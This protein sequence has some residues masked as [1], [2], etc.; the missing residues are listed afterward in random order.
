MYIYLHAFDR[1]SRSG[2]FESLN[3]K[4]ATPRNSLPFRTW[5]VEMRKA[6]TGG[7]MGKSVTTN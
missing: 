5:S 1:Y 3:K 4:P 6:T 2:V 7:Q